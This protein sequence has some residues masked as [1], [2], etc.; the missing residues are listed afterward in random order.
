VTDAFYLPDDHRFV[1]QEWTRGPWDPRFQH[2]GPPSALMGRAIERLEGGEEFAVSRITVEILRSVPLAPLDLEAELLR[3]GRRV[4]LAE[5]TLSDADG[6]V[7]IARA[8]RIRVGDV[9]AIATLD[10]APAFRSPEESA[11]S[12]AY[13]PWNG[14]SYFSAVEWRLAAG[15]FLDPGPAT[16]WMRMRIPLLPSEEPSPL[17]RVLVAADSG[18]GISQVVP[19]DKFL[20]MNTELSVHLHRMPAGEWVCL[21]ART[22]IGA[23]GVGLATSDIYDER[24]RIGS[25]N[26]SLLVSRSE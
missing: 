6:I 4:Q 18:N 22:R 23:E 12:P 9:S 7:A 17:S 16:A 19:I 11:V 20:F 24:G 3:P 2:A 8:W 10:D 1:P 25:G 15:T 14:P 5:A 13:D 26:Q 21:D